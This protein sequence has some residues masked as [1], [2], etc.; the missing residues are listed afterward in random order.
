VPPAVKEFFGAIAARWSSSQHLEEARA[1]MARSFCKALGLGD[2]A[3][4]D[5][6]NADPRASDHNDDEADERLVLS[7]K[8]RW[9]QPEQE[10]STNEATSAPHRKSLRRPNFLKPATESPRLSVFAD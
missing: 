8:L 3:T 5:S 10:V 9:H 1:Q 6:L 2:I 4:A 7:H